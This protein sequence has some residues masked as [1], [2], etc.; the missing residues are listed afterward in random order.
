M[1]KL[2]KQTVAELVGLEREYSAMPRTSSNPLV[3]SDG[4]IGEMRKNGF[5]PHTN[6]V[7]EVI[8]AVSSP[9]AA[10]TT[11]DG[12]LYKVTTIKGDQRLVAYT[13]IVYV[14]MHAG[15]ALLLIMKPPTFDLLR[16]QSVEH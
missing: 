16:R 11:M 5:F 1:L 7:F 15:N 2:L 12:Y 13:Q 9:P 6:F 10:Y 14:P 4:Q 8:C 3:C